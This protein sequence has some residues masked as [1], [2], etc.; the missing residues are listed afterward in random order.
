MIIFRK[1]MLFV[2][3]ML[4]LLFKDTNLSNN[5]DNS[6][7]SNT[8]ILSTIC[9]IKNCL[10]CVNRNECGK[11]QDG[12]IKISHRCYSQNCKL[13]GF[14]LYCDEYDCLKCELGYKLE[15]GL[16]DKY[17]EKTLKGKI[18]FYLILTLLILCIIILLLLS[19]ICWR[20]KKKKNF[21]LNNLF[22]Y[23][24]IKPGNYLLLNEE[25][26]I[27]HNK[28]LTD[29][30][31]NM[32]EKDNSVEHLKTATKSKINFS[33]NCI[34]CG[35]HSDIKADCG[36]CLCNT[37]WREI[38]NNPNKR[39]ICRTHKVYL[40]KTW[41]F[42]LNQKTHYKGN[43]IDKLGLDLC[44]I[45]KMNKGSVSFSCGCSLKVCPKC[46]NDY[47]FVFK[48]NKCPGCGAVCKATD[49]KQKDK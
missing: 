22:K 38:N 23:K 30:T 34:I 26:G 17:E 39:Y 3:I 48:Y 19:L 40:V 6:T 8:H 11:C 43:A 15:Y 41:L 18:I 12:Y 37:H 13:Y 16:C 32:K 10:S 29:S 4:I 33:H 36:C 20:K 27:I 35:R 28:E 47:V 9:D 21:N 42:K 24:K 2:L 31:T 1:K 45:C 5:I 7:T 25:Q 14:C 46:Y 44:P 49:K